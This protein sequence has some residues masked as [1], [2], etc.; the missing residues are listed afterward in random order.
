MKEYLISFQ[1][2]DIKQL[3]SDILKKIQVR[4]EKAFSHPNHLYSPLFPVPAQYSLNS[5]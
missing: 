5:E 4:D 1:E 2:N 3:L